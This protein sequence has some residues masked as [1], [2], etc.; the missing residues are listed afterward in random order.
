MLT[1]F[2]R[3]QLAIFATLTLIALIVLGWYYLRLPALAG[4]GQ[5]TLVVDLPVTGGLYASSNVTYRGATIGKVTDVSP[6]RTG[7]RATLRVADQYRIPAGVSANVHSVSAVGEQYVDLVA[8]SDSGP[9][10][11]N[12]AT[13]TNVTV[14]API[15][16]ALDATDRA[17]SALPQDKIPQLLDETS[18]AVGGLGPMLQRLVDATASVSRDFEAHLGDID[19]VINRSAPVID[20]QIDSATTIRQWSANLDTLS[21]QLADNDANVK[22]I[23]VQAGPAANETTALLG[24]LRDSLPQLLANTAIVTDML[25]R[26]NAGLEQLL[27]VL[28]QGAAIA[29]T[30]TSAFPGRGALDFNVAVNQPPPCL[31][32]YGSASGWRSPADTS[33]QPL[34]TDIQ[35]CKIP[36]DAPY[37]VRGARNYPCADVP[38]KRAATPAECRSDEPYRAAGTN[39]WYGD[40]NQMRN[41]PAPA[42]R[43]DQ[44]VQPGLVVPAPT[45]NTGLNPLPADQL[46][47]PPGLRSD[48]LSPPSQGNVQC[49]GQQPNPCI[50]RPAAA[51]AV[52]TPASGVVSGP[53]GVTYLLRQSGAAD[54]GWKQMLSAAPAAASR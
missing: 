39:P 2:A 37:A 12:G 38:G 28:P 40:P 17:L 30:V 5:Y 41:C 20:S 29:Q 25:K 13:I 31:T 34:P 45:V 35:Y 15:G 33:R 3:I 44:P 19:D 51:T 53:N 24:G 48:P 49:S 42:A 10:L 1:R 11:S 6:T 27:V 16:P 14:P 36:M 18:Q 7:V 32:G 26:Y 52:F 9:F 4:V 23:L 8:D 54:D 22:S 43:C 50:Y 47:S 21:A 46:P